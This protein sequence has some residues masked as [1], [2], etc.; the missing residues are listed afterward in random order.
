MTRHIQSV[1]A[2]KSLECPVHHLPLERKGGEG[3][4]KLACPV[5]LCNAKI[6]NLL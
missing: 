1:S 2:S 4:D 5:C 3:N 6:A